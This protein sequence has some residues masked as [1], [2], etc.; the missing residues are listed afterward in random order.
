MIDQV[1]ELRRWVAEQAKDRTEKILKELQEKQ[2]LYKIS[3]WS[4]EL[5]AYQDMADKIEKD[6]KESSGS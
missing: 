1:L 6:L 3:V 4:G 5:K 2:T